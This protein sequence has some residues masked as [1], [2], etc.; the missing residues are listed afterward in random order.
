MSPPVTIAGHQVVSAL[1]V[2]AGAHAAALRA[3]GVSPSSVE[4]QDPEGTRSLPYLRLPHS[5]PGPSRHDRLLQVVADA[6]EQ[7]DLTPEQ[8]RDCAILVGSSSSTLPDAEDDWATRGRRA[9]FIPMPYAGGHGEIADNLARRFDLHGARHFI[10]TACSSSANALLLGSRLLHGGHA[11]AALVVGVDWYNELTL[12]GFEALMLL[13]P[14]RPRPFDIDRRG[15]V[16]G[17]GVAALVL[18]MAEPA[19]AGAWSLRGGA[20]MGDT[21]SPTHTS[22]EGVAEVVERALGSAGI[23][24]AD[25]TAI[26]AHGTATPHNDVAE[27]QGLARVFGAQQ[28][29]TSSLKG[30]I[31]HTLG[32]C[33]AI[34]TAALMACIDAGFWPASHGLANADPECAI[35]PATAP[36]PCG[37]GLFLLDFF[38][39]G[40]NNCA[41]ILER[42]APL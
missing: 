32:A 29:P 31:G 6:L 8:R 26:K 2:G 42:H 10:G 16:L 1:G 21:D 38:G 15:L 9:D 12:R 40:G 17:E 14:V 25:L 34:E 4:L 27:G 20:T 19:Q 3:G 36:R 23:D 5:D 37:N 41:L 30:A 11:R 18:T 33:G 13:D 22:P 24:S 39:F 28:P 7:A 35:E